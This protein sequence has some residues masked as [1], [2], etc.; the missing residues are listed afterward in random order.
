MADLRAVYRD[1]QDRTYSCP[2]EIH[3]TR[4]FS[5][6]FLFRDATDTDKTMRMSVSRSL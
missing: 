4:T 5:R 2:V 3:N 1:Q 6:P